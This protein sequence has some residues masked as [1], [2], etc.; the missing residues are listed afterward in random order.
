[1]SRRILLTCEDF[2]PLVGGAEVCVWNL[3]LEF[4]R[5]GHT[6]TVYTN[7]VQRM[8]EGEQGIVR[9][10]WAFAAQA[11]VRNVRTLWGLIGTHDIVH[12]QYS[13]RL[14]CLCAIIARIRR[15][16][17]LVTQQGKGIVPEAG[18]KWYH[19]IFIR[20]CQE[21]SMRGATHI[22][23]TSNEITDLSAAF[24]PRSKITV[25]SNGYDA[26]LFHLDASRPVPP[27]FQQAHG[28]P[29]ILTVRRLVPKNGI[30]ILIQALALVRDRNP[31][32]HY[33]SIGEGR[34]QPFI[35]QLVKEY[36]LAGH[37]TLLGAHPNETLPAYY[38]HADVVIIPSSAEATSI[39]CIEAMGMGK[40]L[41]CSRVGGLIDLL[42]K[43][44]FYGLL[45][46][47]YG[48]EQCNYAPP[49]YLPREELQPLADAI[50]DF[51]ENPDPFRERA[52]RA[53][54]KV[55]KEHTWSAIA[56]RYLRLYDQFL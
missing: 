18:T 26:G 13:F 19:K 35:E 47:I 25:I 23:S 43:D 12:C 49:D 40:P 3:A 29:V 42:G 36:D 39:A 33:L 51:F 15:R 21:I 7:T 37:V 32:F 48:S 45:V 8:E 10:Q 34:V 1:M 38:Q 16:P 44:S 2:L 6:V 11:L 30:H 5:R 53:R 31:R 22:T 17:L 52:S 27:E 54:Q 9:V 28:A 41:I 55:E 24:V 20:I 14:A 46:S 4:R 50:V 56:D